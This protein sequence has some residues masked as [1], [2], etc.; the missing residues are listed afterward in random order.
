MI[1]SLHLRITLWYAAILAAI[2]IGFSVI[3]YQRIAQELAQTTDTSLRITAGQVV[4]AIDFEKGR[5]KLQTGPLARSAFA[6]D[7][8]D[9]WLRVLDRQG[10]V[11]GG[12]GHYHDVPVP[13]EL[14]VATQQQQPGFATIAGAA[15][16]VPTR[17]Y[18]LPFDSAD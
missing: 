9:V 3:V 15:Q 6:F 5:P 11:L 13:A 16:G 18:S 8:A 4:D 10:Q 14:V 12:V 7:K 17:I 2:L 1:K